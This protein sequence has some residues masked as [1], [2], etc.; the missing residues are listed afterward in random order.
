MVGE[1]RIGDHLVICDRSGFKCWASET[2][3][4]WT[5]LRVR[6][7]LADKSRHPQD[8]VRAVPDKQAVANP[9]SEPTD[10]YLSATVLASDL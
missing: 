8:F 1:Q 9:R 5:G 6:R 3:V 10:T 2:L 7:D 4:E